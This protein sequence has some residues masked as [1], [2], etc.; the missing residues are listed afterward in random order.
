MAT[1]IP[2]NRARFFYHE[3]LVATGGTA[4]Q[5]G[6]EFVEGVSTDTR[7]VKPGNVFVAL[8]GARYDGHAYAAEAAERGARAVVVAQEVSVP[9]GIGVIRV[10]DTLEALGALGRAHRR[11]WS[12]RGS[13]GRRVVGITG[14][15][16]K[17]TTRVVTAAVLQ[18]AGF[19][20]HASRG[21][22]NNA[23][24]IPMVLLGLEED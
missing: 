2:E 12:A 6:D 1:P 3:L 4:I 14:S 15:V 16:G 11:R 18:A 5:G 22:L 21:N 10:K 20:V 8:V 7:S 9:A 19:S 17:T 13:A 24:G 23:V